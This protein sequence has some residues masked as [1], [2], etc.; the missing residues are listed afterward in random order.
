M[1]DIL[2]ERKNSKSTKNV[3][4]TKRNSILVMQENILLKRRETLSVNFLFKN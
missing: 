4:E 2:L 3:L 1:I